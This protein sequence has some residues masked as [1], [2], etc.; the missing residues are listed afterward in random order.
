ML[1]PLPPP[2]GSTCVLLGMWPE[3]PPVLQ[4][5]SFPHIALSL[6]VFTTQGKLITTLVTLSCVSCR[7]YATELVAYF[8]QHGWTCDDC[9]ACIV[10]DQSPSES[11]KSED[12][13]VSSAQL[14]FYATSGDCLTYTAHVKVCEYCDQ[15]IHYSC[16]APQPEKRPKVQKE[17]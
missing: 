1:K 7:V 3:R 16:L 15:G 11:E 13:L 4:V 8:E 6:C 5:T 2:G 17:C 10:C 9:K 14:D 12:L